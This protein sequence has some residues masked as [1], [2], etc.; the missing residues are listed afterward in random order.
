[1]ARII[2]QNCA[3][4][5]F[6]CVEVQIWEKKPGSCSW[7]VHCHSWIHDLGEVT[8]VLHGTILNLCI[9]KCPQYCFPMG[10]YC[11]KRGKLALLID[12]SSWSLLFPVTTRKETT[13]SVTE[14]ILYISSCN[15]KKPAAAGCNGSETPSGLWLVTQFERPADGNLRIHLLSISTSVSEHITS[16]ASVWNRI[17]VCPGQKMFC[18]VL[19]GWHFHPRCQP[20]VEQ[21]M[22]LCE[23]LSLTR[24]P[25]KLDRG[26][27]LKVTLH[28][29]QY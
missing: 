26:A 14:R 12:Q 22:G 17:C 25:C 16:V 19:P 23:S 8:I 3:S 13:I 28:A 5:T 27:K 15:I 9:I 7:W 6:C 1:M 24:R 18:N 29:G 20:D 10:L 11:S 4:I 2:A 21:E